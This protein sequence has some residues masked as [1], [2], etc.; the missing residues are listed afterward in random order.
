MT[1]SPATVDSRLADSHPVLANE[2]NDH[3]LLAPAPAVRQQVQ[4]AR[5]AREVLGHEELPALAQAVEARRVH[6]VL[7]QLKVVVE[8]DL[9]QEGLENLRDQIGLARGVE[10]LAKLVH[11]PRAQAVELEVAS[12]IIEQL[13]VLVVLVVSARTRTRRALVRTLGRRSLRSC[14]GAAATAAA[15]AR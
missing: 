6:H 13:I 7:D 2:I 8:Q 15:A 11:V 10:V 4:F 12:D 3:L 14:R 1:F 5:H 9:A